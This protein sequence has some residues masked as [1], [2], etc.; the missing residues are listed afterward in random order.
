MDGGGGCAHKS[1]VETLAAWANVIGV[2]ASPFD[3]YLTLRGLRT[4][5]PRVERQQI[6]AAKIAAYLKAHPAVADVHYPGLVSHP[7]HAIARS[8]KWGSGPC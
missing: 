2:T 8:S 7:G 4:L 1:N 5:Y 3:C 6:T